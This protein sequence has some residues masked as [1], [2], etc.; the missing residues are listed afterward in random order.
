MSRSIDELSRLAHER[1]QALASEVI[2]LQ[3]DL[4]DL[5]EELALANSEAARWRKMY[6]AIASPGPLA[7]WSQAGRSVAVDA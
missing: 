7:G 3:Q 4:D 2:A 5:R 6:E 1:R